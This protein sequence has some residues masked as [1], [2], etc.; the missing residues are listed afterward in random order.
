MLPLWGNSFAPACKFK[1]MQ[2]YFCNKKGHIA[3]VCRSK[4][5]TIHQKS[6]VKKNFYLH[7]RPEDRY[8]GE[9]KLFTLN[10]P[11]SQPIKI[12]VCINDVPVEIDLD[13][14]ASLSVISSS[15]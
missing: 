4:Q 8:E 9:Y 12:N 3:K 11:S 2:C 6:G 14:G 13:T 15:T 10:T 7:D 1:D 5:S